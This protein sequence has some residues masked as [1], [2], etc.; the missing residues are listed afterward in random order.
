MA[1]LAEQRVQDRQLDY[2]RKD[3]QGLRALAVLAVVA[4]HADLPVPGGF[5]GVDVFFVISGFVITG[6]LCRE[7]TR[8]GRVDFARFYW[9]RFKRLT[10]ALAFMIL[11]VVPAAGF[12]LPPA[13]AQ[14]ATV[15]TA[16]G[17]IMLV[18]NL[19]IAR[20]SG[21]YFGVEAGQNLLLHTWSLSV[22]EQF[23]LLFPLL[24]L[25]GWMV[26]RRHRRLRHAPVAVVTIVGVASLAVAVV[27]SMGVLIPLMP[28][29][30]AGFYGPLG[31]FWEFAAGALLGL[32]SDRLRRIP[33]RASTAIG[34]LGLALLIVSLVYIDDEATHPGPATVLPVI[35]TT[36]MIIAGI[37]SR[38][39]FSRALSLGPLVALG[40][41]SYSWYLWHW[42]AI[43]LA[44]A[45]APGWSWV[46]LAAAVLSV[47]PAFISYRWVEQPL[48]ELTVAPG[49][50]SVRLVGFI[51]VP[52]VAASGLI[53]LAV[54]KAYWSQE[55][56]QFQ[57][58][59]Q[60][61]IG[62]R[63]G[64][65]T[66]EPLELRDLEGCTWN[67]DAAGAPIYLIGDSIAEQFSEGVITAGESLQR[68]VV[69]ASGAGCTPY[70]VDLS[71][72][73]PE[74]PDEVDCEP[75][76]DSLVPWFRGQEVGL[77]ILGSTDISPWHPR[78]G[79]SRSVERA[80]AIRDGLEGPVRAL[81]EMGHDVLLAQA[82]PSFRYPE[83][84]WSMH[85]CS[86]WTVL[87]GECVT[88][89]PLETV[90]GVQGATRRAIQQVADRTGAGV[91]DLRDYLCDEE[92][93]FSQNGSTRYM[94]QDDLHLSV[95]ASEKLAP[96][97]VRAISSMS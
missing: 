37:G 48:R 4:F 58:A 89:L 20:S 36:L 21:D 84:G 50:G 83:P 88:Q 8:S 94:Y 95:V 17:A 68:P 46:P 80:A 40:D 96:E 72:L 77:V 43:V 23:Y 16:L 29:S 39:V 9:R 41:R 74:S 7:W 62:Y 51:L 34:T 57:A 24:M 63:S 10:P 87:R 76:V 93:C 86:V 70:P 61:H 82:P 65:M 26:A 42:P 30:L 54:Q 64:C 73:G 2:R 66:Y 33:G 6:M 81:N 71:F 11:V 35:A 27:G 1:V 75:F 90:D 12:I 91:F 49:L 15:E 92:N 28:E 5:L 97:F 47:I 53:G 78:D 56:R 60:T 32:L 3:I 85:R 44:T 38:N 22:E 79:Q 52:P 19:V 14:R 18:A 45:V 59:S 55:V 13:T 25:V 67:P 69:I 31:R